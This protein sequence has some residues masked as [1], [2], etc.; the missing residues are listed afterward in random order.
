MAEAPEAD[1]LTPVDSAMGRRVA[2]RRNRL[3]ISQRQLAIKAKVDRET[4]KKLEDGNP[5]TRETT[6]QVVLATLDALEHEMEM[7]RPD[8]TDADLVEYV[9]KVPGGTAEVTVRGRLSSADDLEERVARLIE[10]MNRD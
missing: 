8:A 6:V 3:G 1:T 10:R 5:R 7:D 2:E 9:V 4:L